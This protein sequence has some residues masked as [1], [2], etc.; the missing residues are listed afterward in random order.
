MISAI[1]MLERLY[2]LNLLKDAPKWWWVNAGSFEVML[3]CVLVQ[4][5]KW[6][7]VQKTL[8]SLRKAGILPTFS[9]DFMQ[10]YTDEA[11]NYRAI[12]NIAALSQDVLSSHILGLQNQKA[13]RLILL[14]RNL[15]EDFDSYT[16]MT[17]HLTRQ[18]LLAQKG[19]GRES[20]DCV[21]NYMCKREVLVV[22]RYTYKLLCALGVE[23]EEY[24][25]LQRFCMRGVEEN[26]ARVYALYGDDVD[27]AY[28][29]ARFHAKI[30][31]F[32]KSKHSPTLLQCS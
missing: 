6:E 30:V 18:W 23:I 14:A 15:L 27:L 21:L 1:E 3:G 22:D 13:Q 29:Y 19:L 20:A 12:C 5:S 8:D 10:D 17:Q 32:A 16:S 26:L 31:E 2:A 9:G 7:N 4:N 11:R 24:D 28:V 25:E